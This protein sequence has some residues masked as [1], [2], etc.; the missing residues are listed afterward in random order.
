MGLRE[1]VSASC[2]VVAACAVCGIPGTATGADLG[3]GP[4]VLDVASVPSDTWTI[5]ATMYG[6]LAYLKGD[7][8]VRGRTANIDVNP[9]ELFQHLTT[10]GGHIPA[11][12]SYME[13]RRGPLSFYNDIFYANLGLS[14]SQVRI[15]P[16]RPDIGVSLGL[17]FEQLVI[18][19]GAAYEI[20]RWSSGGGAKDWDVPERET[21]LDIV[22]GARYWRQVADLKLALT[23][24]LDLPGVVVV[25]NR[26]FARS[27]S[28][29][30]VDPLVGLR[31]R[32]Q[33]MPGH[34]VAV[35]GDIGGFGAGSQFSWQVVGAYS[36]DF[37]VRDGITYSGMLGYRALDVDYEQGSGRRK[38]TYDVLQH[39]PL[40]GLT[41]GF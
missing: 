41:F 30:W 17:D 3:A 20:A 10:D 26:A 36:W 28:I 35:R 38:Y 22:A 31:L 9:I 11:W 14:G 13:A 8:T 12:M 5:R 6:W 2:F 1:T 16:D 33:F 23:A 15:R 32:H 19:T 40:L 37:A 39:G 27:G 34:E 21:S 7:I 25:G 29:D 4:P 24:E 18:E